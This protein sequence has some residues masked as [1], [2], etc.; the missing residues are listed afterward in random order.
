MSIKKLNKLTMTTKEG[1]DILIN[2]VKNNDELENEVENNLIET[3]MFFI[4][5][6]L[7][8]LKGIS[9]YS[10]GFY[11]NN[12]IEIYRDLRNEIN[13]IDSCIEISNNYGVFNIDEDK[14]VKELYKK[15]TDLYYMDYENQNY[16]NLENEVELKIDELRDLLVSKFNDMTNIDNYDIEGYLIDSSYIDKLIDNNIVYYYDDNNYEL[17]TKD[18]YINNIKVFYSNGNVENEIS[19][20]TGISKQYLKEKLNN[21]IECNGSQVIYDIDNPLNIFNNATCIGFFINEY[22]LLPVTLM[23]KD[24][25]DILL[26][27]IIVAG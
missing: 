8:E 21:Y 11:N 22:E 23:E 6:I 13:F 12:F 14:W 18:E 4:R 15:A 10:I 25:T 26:N 2:L 16:N 27:M 9:N 24:N 19:E 7:D 1:K 5:E 20:Y 3:E 17:K